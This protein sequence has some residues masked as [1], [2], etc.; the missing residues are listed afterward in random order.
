MHEFRCGC[1]RAEINT[2]LFET[3]QELRDL[4]ARPERNT[5]EYRCPDHNRSK[6]GKRR[7]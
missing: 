6:G 4:A 3:L 2:A 7:S 1:G 5:S